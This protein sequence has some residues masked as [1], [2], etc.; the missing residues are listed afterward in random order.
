MIKKYLI[1]IFILWVGS[2]ATAQII[3]TEPVQINLSNGSYI[4]LIP[5][6][7][8]ISIKTFNNSNLLYPSTLQINMAGMQAFTTTDANMTLSN[9]NYSGTQDNLSYVTNGTANFNMTAQMGA[10]NTEYLV[11]KNN[12]NDSTTNSSSSRYVTILKTIT[13]S[14]E[15]IIRI[16]TAPEPE[17]QIIGTKNPILTFTDASCLGGSICTSKVYIYSGNER[18]GIL[19]STG[20][21]I[22]ITNKTNLRILLEESTIS[23]LNSPDQMQ[24]TIKNS[25]GSIFT[26]ILAICIIFTLYFIIKNIFSRKG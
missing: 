8:V 13:G 15:W 5:P 23:Q 3:V 22:S 16:L 12:V 14:L 4:T 24:S 11:I 9:I 6:Q 18:I 7:T 2:T 19:N 10:A 25:W 21:Y 1:L 26:G 20:T 17:I